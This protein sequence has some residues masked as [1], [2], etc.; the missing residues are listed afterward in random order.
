[1]W[2]P[3]M[4]QSNWY[5]S[6]QDMSLLCRIIHFRWENKQLSGVSYEKYRRR[7]LLRCLK[8][9]YIHIVR[10]SRSGL[11]FFFFSFM[12]CFLEVVCFYFRVWNFSW[13]P[14]VEISGSCQGLRLLKSWLNPFTPEHSFDNRNSSTFHAIAIILEDLVEK[15][16][17][18]LICNIFH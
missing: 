15:S 4:K 11:F 17:L 12:L 5:T 14:S 10:T 7:T 16:N 1:M 18:G 9:R 2:A 3:M 13:I 8:Y 6:K